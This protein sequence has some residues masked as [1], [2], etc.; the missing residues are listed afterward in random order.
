MKQ[1]TTNTT[2]SGFVSLFLGLYLRFAGQDQTTPFHNFSS[3]EERAVDEAAG[4]AVL[5]E[6]VER[7]RAVEA[8]DEDSND[9]G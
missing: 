3:K 7:G 1:H 5:H 6:G 9:A 2:Y 8:L 4:I